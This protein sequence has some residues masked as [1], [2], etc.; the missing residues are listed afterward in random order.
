MPSTLAFCSGGAPCHVRVGVGAVGAWGTTWTPTATSTSP[1]TS[2]ISASTRSRTGLAAGAAATPLVPSTSTDCL[3]EEGCRGKGRAS[4]LPSATTDMSRKDFPGPWRSRSHR[5]K[6]KP[7]QQQG[8]RQWKPLSGVR[9][10]LLRRLG[11][12]RE[13]P[14]PPA[15]GVAQRPHTAGVARGQATTTGATK[16]GADDLELL[17]PKHSGVVLLPPLSVVASVA[18]ETEQAFAAA[19]RAVVDASRPSVPFVQ[20][21]VSLEGLPVL[22]ARDACVLAATGCSRFGCADPGRL[23]DTVQ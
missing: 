6:V 19:G 3:D 14:P 15:A 16:A 13:A 10:L 4:P 2:R 17:L 20:V 1:M 21:R 7:Q 22:P 18:K 5:A 9:G 23:V 12:Q 11:E 8:H